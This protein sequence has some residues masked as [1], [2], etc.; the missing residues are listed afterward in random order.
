MAEAIQKFGGSPGNLKSARL[1]DRRVLGYLELHIE[2]GPVLEQKEMPLG[3]VSAIAG[4]TRSE[5]RFAGQAGHAGTV[6]MK[7]RRDALC[8]A[9]EFSVAVEH[10]ARMVGGLLATVGQFAAFPGAT[11]VIPGEV[12]LSLDV[13]HADDETRNRACA[14]MKDLACRIGSARKVQ[15]SMRTLHEADSVVC[16]RRLSQVLSTTVKKRVGRSITL[17]SGA[18]H[19]AAA[20]AAI[21]PVA[22]LF[23]RCRGGISHHPNESVKVRDIRAAISVVSDFI[24]QLAGRN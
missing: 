1:D 21:T 8:A 16:D 22:M 9:A 12:V 3:V 4:Q 5:L 19:D 15:V 11:N 17:A 13:R 18:G 10:R 20:M 6:P 14:Q 24:L 23:V 2:Q 7:L